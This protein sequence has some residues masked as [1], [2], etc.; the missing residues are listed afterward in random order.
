VTLEEKLRAGGLLPATPR[1]PL[2]LEEAA[3]TLAQMESAVSAGF[4]RL[5]SD[6]TRGDPPIDLRRGASK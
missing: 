3:R 2:T 1:R 4:I 5:H 6:H